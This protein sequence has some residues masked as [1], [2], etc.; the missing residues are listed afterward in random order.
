MVLWH[1][2]GSGKK[3]CKCHHKEVCPSY[4]TADT[5]TAS[6]PMENG[7][8]KSKSSKKF[9]NDSRTI[10]KKSRRVIVERFHSYRVKFVA[11]VDWVALFKFPE[12]RLN[13]NVFFKRIDFSKAIVKVFKKSI[14]ITLRSSCDIKGLPVREA[15]L[16]A[17]SI[18]EE[19]VAQ[20]PKAIVVSGSN[21]SSVHNAFMNHPTALHNVTVEVNG[22]KRLI[23]DN[24]H[25]VSEFEAIHPKFAISDSE[26]L[27]QDNAQLIDKGLSRDVLAN[28]IKDLISDRAYHAKNMESHVLAI[29]ELAFAI[30]RLNKRL[31]K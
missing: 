1:H 20:L 5:H 12:F 15:K 26:A 29:R 6:F 24:S 18:I 27:E 14:L 23:S 16:K 25:G 9:T 30:K 17:D 4:P 2:F 13:N 19:I 11:D 7:I 8:V 10:T 22:E 28:A 3:V 31:I 21:V